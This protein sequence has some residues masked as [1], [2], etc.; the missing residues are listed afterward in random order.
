MKFA[1]DSKKARR[2]KAKRGVD[3]AEATDVFAD[4]FSS[5]VAD[6][7]HSVSELRFLIFGRS[8]TGRYLA[9]WFTDRLGTLRI[10][11]ARRTPHAARRMTRRE[12]EAYEL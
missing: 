2:N 4:I 12:R 8:R 6:P 5:S 11:S 7:D 1:W 9:V 10:I 3:F